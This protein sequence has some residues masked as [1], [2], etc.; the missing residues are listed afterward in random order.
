M[1]EARP[2][3]SEL[4]TKLDDSGFV[5]V[6]QL[7]DTDLTRQLA[8]CM[9][10]VFDERA[11][12]DEPNQH[13]RGL[14]ELVPASDLPL[15]EAALLDPSCLSLADSVLGDDF[16]LAEVGARRFHPGAAG[17]PLHVGVPANRF[18]KRGLPAPEQCLVLTVSWLLD[19]VSRSNGVRAF[20]PCS[21]LARRGPRRDQHYD[22]LAYIEA[23]AGSVILFNSA[24]WHAVEPYADPTGSRCELASAYVVPWLDQCELG[25]KAPSE[26]VLN[27]LSPR[28]RQL[29][30]RP[31]ESKE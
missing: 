10:R 31:A 19:E 17:L 16:R 11:P 6:E 27:Q 23:P 4:K 30:Q 25:W 3:V 20:L 29:N 2:D 21:H 26:P 28:L 24:V 1:T 18:I 13:L 14:L 7:M 12:A 15:L 9:N 22:H 5:V 8:D